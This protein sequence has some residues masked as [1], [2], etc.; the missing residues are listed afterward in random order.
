ML[1]LFRYR[2]SSGMMPREEEDE[3]LATLRG[4]PVPRVL[5]LLLGN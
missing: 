4:K 3:T 5:Q 1:N 2:I